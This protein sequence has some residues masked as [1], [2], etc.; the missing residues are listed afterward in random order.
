M[1]S[2]ETRIF[3][4]ARSLW[5]NP[6]P[7]RYCIPRATCWEKLRSISES[8]AIGSSPG[9]LT[10]IDNSHDCESV[11]TLLLQLTQVLLNADGPS[12]LL[13]ALAQQLALTI[14][15]LYINFVSPPPPPCIAILVSVYLLVP[16]CWQLHEGWQCLDVWT[17]PWWLPLG[18]TSPCPHE[19]SLS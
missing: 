4:A 15:Y 8:P 11:A 5:T 6:F 1:L 14:G 10:Y 2:F 16:Y 9:L 17:E 3:L 12:S 7:E 13:C 18:G 19:W